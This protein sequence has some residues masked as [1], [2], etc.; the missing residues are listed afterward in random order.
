MQ[1]AADAAEVDPQRFHVMLI[2]VV[3]QDVVQVEVQ[4]VR[5]EAADLHA[6]LQEGRRSEVSLGQESVTRRGLKRCSPACCPVWAAV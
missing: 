6:V 1:A 2:V 4:D 5:M 3:R